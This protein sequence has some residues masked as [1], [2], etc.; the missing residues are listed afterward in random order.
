MNLEPLDQH[1]VNLPLGSILS[2][3]ISQFVVS[4]LQYHAFVYVCVHAC[5]IIYASMH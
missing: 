4:H 2:P 3:Y 5:L 1:Y